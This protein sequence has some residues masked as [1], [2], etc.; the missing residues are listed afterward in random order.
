MELSKILNEVSN[1]GPV[2]RHACSFPQGQCS[3]GSGNYRKIV[4]H[5]FGRNKMC[6]KMIPDDVWVYYCRKHY[7]RARYRMTRSWPM[8]QAD[9][10][11]KTIDN[12]QEWGG[13][14]SFKLALRRRETRRVVSE[15]TMN[16]DDDSTN[17]QQPSFEGNEG[18]ERGLSTS[19]ETP[20]SEGEFTIRKRSPTI[21]TCPVPKWLKMHIGPNKS[22]PEVRAILQALKD[23]LEDLQDRG[24]DIR[25]PDVEILPQVKPNVRLPD[26][27]A[28][29]Q[30]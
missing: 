26:R 16:Y 12:L 5:I 30:C 23:Y 29:T 27:G 6:T 21:V 15:S 1:N 24:Y 22:F 14:E 3:T 4:S 11:L 10:A 19:P 7:Q 28:S 8:T 25:F 20:F 13:V 17:L 2:D 9:L 18:P